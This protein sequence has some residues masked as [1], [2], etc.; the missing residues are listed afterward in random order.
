MRISIYRKISI[1]RA[2]CNAA[3]NARSATL[4]CGVSFCLAMAVL[5]LPP[6]PAQ[7]GW[8][9]SYLTEQY[10][11]FNYTEDG[12]YKGLSVDLLRLTWKEL[13][14]PPHPIQIMPWARAYDRACNVSNT[15]LFSMARIPQRE[16]LSRWV[17]PIASTR[18]VLI[19]KKSSHI[20]LSDMD[21]AE[22]YR[23]GTVRD[24]VADALLRIH[25][26]RNKIEAV[27]DM[28][29]NIRKLTDDRLDM[30]A[31]EESAWSKIVQKYGLSPDDYETVCVVRETP[32][33]YAFHPDVSPILVRS[34]Q[35]AL[36]RVKATAQYREMLSTYL[37]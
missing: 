19:A 10:Y 12:E 6:P 2:L 25:A 30:V 15:V 7:A 24:D 17:G 13:G 11:P 22:G 9:L 36:D 34:F 33:Y 16:D 5:M 29:H 3:K 26:D 28:L 32:V 37:H 23:I 31:Y 1:V 27:A 8:E 21:E 35:A 20:R 4:A 14:E 18:F